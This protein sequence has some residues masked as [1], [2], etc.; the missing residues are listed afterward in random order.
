MIAEPVRARLA[1]LPPEAA[2]PLAGIHQLASA[3]VDPAILALCSACIDAIL[4]DHSW[5][6]PRPLTAREQA[7]VDFSEQFA[8]S[9]STLDRAQVERL[10]G[11]ASEDELYLFVNALYV[12]DMR[13]RLDLVAGRILA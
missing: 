13:R 1:A 9:V 6:P 11:F 2:T 7:F 3:A 8:T 10:R 4:N 12:L 5:V